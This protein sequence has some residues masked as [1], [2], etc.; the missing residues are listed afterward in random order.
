MTAK[1][2]LIFAVSSISTFLPFLTSVFLLKHA[3]KGKTLLL[4]RLFFT[5]AALTEI[6]LYFFSLYNK[7]SGWVFHV[8]TFVEYILIAS[9]LADWQNKPATARLI[10]QSIL[11]YAL[12][13]VFTKA[14]GL[15]N[16]SADKANYITRPFAIL[17]MLASAFLSLRDLWEKLPTN[18]THDYR[19][20]MLL[21]MILYYS[22][23]LVLFAFM[24]TKN[25]VLL[26]GLFK[27]HAVINIIHNLL[28]TIGIFQ[29][30]RTPQAAL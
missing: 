20:W 23:S 2:H 15:E 8:F 19:Y 22:T 12:F 7:Q 21:A 14:V 30:R 4:W 6:I 24:F 13:F 26:M 29:I 28:F 3:N 9:I 18:L 5:F 11:F 1:Y 25:S 16:F 17:L 27:I 10:R